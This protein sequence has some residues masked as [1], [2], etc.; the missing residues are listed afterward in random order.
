DWP[1]LDQDG[2]PMSENVSMVE[3]YTMSDDETEL[4]Y[5]IVITDP[6]NLV[7]PAIWDHTWVYKP[8]D[9][10]LP[11]FEEGERFECEIRDSDISIYR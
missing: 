7:E 2:R 9:E 1:Y 4:K 5:E 10:M 11:G 3:R 8:G 6:E